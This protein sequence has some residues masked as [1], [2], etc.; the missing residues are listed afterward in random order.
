MPMRVSILSNEV[1]L[2]ISH[3]V[4]YITL[5]IP[6]FNINII[7]TLIKNCQHV[8]QLILLLTV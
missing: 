4:L 7:N 8:T 3:N 1:I 6:L 5:Y 2:G